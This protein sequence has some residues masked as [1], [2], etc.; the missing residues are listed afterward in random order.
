M[1]AASCELHPGSHGVSPPHTLCRAEKNN[2]KN[3]G[4]SSSRWKVFRLGDE[5][6]AERSERERQRL[7]T[8]LCSGALNPR[9]L[10][11][12]PLPPTAAHHFQHLSATLHNHPTLVQ[13]NWP[14]G[15]CH[16][17]AWYRTPPPSSPGS[18]RRRQRHQGFSSASPSPLYSILVFFFLPALSGR[19]RRR[20]FCNLTLQRRRSVIKRA[21]D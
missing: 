12:L 19:W 18:L 20:R 7:M 8:R 11:S 1:F 10:I 13:P 6:K 5:Q 15:S 21:A 14:A 3:P 9:Q 2:K 4:S 16:P 17:G